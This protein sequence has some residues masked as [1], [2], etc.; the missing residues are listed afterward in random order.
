MR[1]IGIRFTL[2]ADD[3][4]KVTGT[5]I[6]MMYQL[7]KGKESGSERIFIMVDKFTKERL[8][9]GR[10]TCIHLRWAKKAPDVFLN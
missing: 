3:K 10:F 6:N 8:R 1:I 7:E 9:Q 4:K 5:N 2:F